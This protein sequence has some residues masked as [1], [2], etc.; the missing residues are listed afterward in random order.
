MKYKEGQ[1]VYVWRGDIEDEIQE[2]TITGY[3]GK[4]FLGEDVYEFEYND[5]KAMSGAGESDIFETL[6]KA[7]LAKF[8]MA[9]T[10]REI[11]IELEKTM[12][13]KLEK[14]MAHKMEIIMTKEMKKLLP[15]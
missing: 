1:K 8:K 11:F 6:Q 15:E 7:Q 14:T 5:M 12:A 9:K 13:H 4:A 2:A 3:F 10:I